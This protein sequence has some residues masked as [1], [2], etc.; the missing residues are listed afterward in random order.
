MS[1]LMQQPGAAPA[2]SEENNVLVFSP[3]I[4]T[5]PAEPLL[6]DAE[7]SAIRV[8]LREFALVKQSCPMARRITGEQE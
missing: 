7:R 8:M 4:R 6:T 5:T 2:D 1:Q 3:R